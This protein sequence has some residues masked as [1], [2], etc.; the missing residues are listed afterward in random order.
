MNLTDILLAIVLVLLIVIII[1]F[2]V[3]KNDDK[4]DKLRNN[5]SND[6]NNF[7]NNLNK[8]LNNLNQLTNN[9]LNNFQRNINENLSNSFKATNDTF[10]RISERMVK[11]DEAQKGLNELSSNIVSLENILQ[12]KKSRGTFGEVELYS[13]LETAFGVNNDRWA[14][15][16]QLSSGLRADAVIF[17]GE[18]LGVICVDSKF[19]LENYR[20]IYDDNLTL[21]EKEKAKKEFKNNVIKHINDI[22]T[23]YIVPGET[24]EMAY[25][26]LPAEAIFAEIYANFDEI[27]EKSYE[28][29]VYIVSPTTLMAY[30][31]AIR[32]IYLGQT[33][34][35]KAK[36]IEKLLAELSVEFDR[37]KTRN[38]KLYDDYKK[39]D[40][41]FSS[42]NVTSD[43]ITKRF[44]KINNGDLDEE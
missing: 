22:K 15:Q 16:Y 19:P 1:L 27:V 2:F 8:S 6:L 7:Q 4:E 25:M 42:L 28:S 9:Q 5:I 14:K 30:L 29:K 31:T 13:L 37:F 33:K 11:I 12:D 41:D 40:N 34:D 43:K 44:E 3:N 23:K 35:K 24:A 39:L 38:E 32:S 26:F 18:S 36:E 17:G 21:E 10:N 20:R